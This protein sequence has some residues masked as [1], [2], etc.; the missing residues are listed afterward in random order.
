M[1]AIAAGFALPA[2]AADHTDGSVAGEPGADIGDFYA[3]MS[4]TDANKVVL[5]MTVNPLAAVDAAFSDAVIYTFGIA[6]LADEEGMHISCWFEA[7]GA[8]ACEAPGGIELGGMVGG[9]PATGDSVRAW[10]GLRD[11]PFFFDLTAFRNVVSGNGERPFCVLDPEAD[12][13]E[14]FFAGLNVLAL[15][16]E[17][18]KSIL[19]AGGEEN[20]FL[21][22]WAATSRRQ[23]EEGGE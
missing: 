21:G 10:A 16:V 22:L 23:A 8:Y 15:V 9:D 14:D 13:G 2:Q 7:D 12:S 19:F 6:R 1:A 20:E 17:V 5:A 4:P 18:D 3:F 11:D